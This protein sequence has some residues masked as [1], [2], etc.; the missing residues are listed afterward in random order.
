MNG[1]LTNSPVLD[2]SALSRNS[3][4]IRFA[5]LH[6]RDTDSP[7]GPL[8][9]FVAERRSFALDLL[10]F[11]HTVWPLSEGLPIRATTRQ[12]MTAM[13]IAEN[14]ESRS[15]FSRSW[16]W[17]ESRRLV[18]IHSRG[19]NR[20]IEI[21]KEDGSGEAWVTPGVVKDS[22]FRLSNAYWTGGFARDLSLPGKA[23][24]LIGLSRQSREQEFFELPLQRGSGWYGISPS[25][26]QRGLK[27]LRDIDLL[28]RWVEERRTSASPTGRTYDQRFDL[29]SLEKVGIQR[30]NS[31]F[32]AFDLDGEGEAILF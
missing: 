30:A 29:R 7:A 26:V 8:S 17:L 2:L 11:A 6:R 25:T 23:V 5:F 20:G 15:T 27:E 1:G 28:R 22:Y 10:L 31:N 19:R 32:E 18:R 24:L 13:A 12:W 14:A 21:L 16:R 9:W 3:L 4:P